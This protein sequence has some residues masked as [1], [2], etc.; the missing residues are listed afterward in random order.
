MSEGVA[1]V[2]FINDIPL[3]ENFN[4]AGAHNKEMIEGLRSCRNDHCSIYKIFDFDLG[5]DLLEIRG[6]QRAK[7]RLLR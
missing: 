3:I 1:G 2:Q 4:A 5:R 6:A 7:G